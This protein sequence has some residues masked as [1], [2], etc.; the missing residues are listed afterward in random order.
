MQ[1]A[2]RDL[3]RYSPC[4][5]CSQSGETRVLAS[6]M[7]GANMCP[8]PAKSPRELVSPPPGQHPVAG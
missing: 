6:P 7:T 1:I 5:R 3:S 8:N 4:W 2:S